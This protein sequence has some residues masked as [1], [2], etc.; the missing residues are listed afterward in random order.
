ME[1]AGI[2][3]TISWSQADYATIQRLAMPL[4]AFLTFFCTVILCL[5]ELGA[6]NGFRITES[7]ERARLGLSNCQKIRTWDGLV[8]SLEIVV[9]T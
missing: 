2:E 7:Q 8:G 9:R 5:L 4:I 3:S 1:A 6:M